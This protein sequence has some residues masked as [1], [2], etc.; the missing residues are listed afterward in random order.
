MYQI[1]YVKYRRRAT[2][3]YRSHVHS[4]LFRVEMTVSYSTRIVYNRTQTHVRKT[5]DELTFLSMCSAIQ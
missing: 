5:L 1:L 2:H 4:N 3:A